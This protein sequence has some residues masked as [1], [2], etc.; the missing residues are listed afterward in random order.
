MKMAGQVWWDED[1]SG[2]LRTRSHTS[3]YFRSLLRLKLKC[4]PCISYLDRNPVVSLLI[5]R[6]L[7]IQSEYVLLRRICQ[8]TLICKPSLGISN[9]S[10]DH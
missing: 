3:L 10:M 1:A 7:S 9:T 2:R 5:L 6:V 8:V 4:S